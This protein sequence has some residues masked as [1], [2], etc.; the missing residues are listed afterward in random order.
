MSNSI[1]D[2]GRGAVEHLRSDSNAPGLV[3]G[4]FDGLAGHMLKLSCACA[5][6]KRLAA[7]ATRFD[8]LL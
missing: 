2:T 3:A 4:D 5:V 6:G 8:W 7:V 1:Q